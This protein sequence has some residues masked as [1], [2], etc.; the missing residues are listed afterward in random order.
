MNDWTEDS[1]LLSSMVLSFPQWR[2]K[3]LTE[4]DGVMWVLDRLMD[5]NDHG[6]MTN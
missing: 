5:D 1:Y 2:N 3:I 6:Q 4:Q